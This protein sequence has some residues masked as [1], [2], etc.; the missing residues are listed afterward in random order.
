MPSLAVTTV[1]EFWRLTNSNDFR[2]DRAIS[3]FTLR[4]GRICRIVE[5]WPEPFA[6]PSNRAHLVESMP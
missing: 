3:F 5:Y 2:H 6:P 1:Y 4:D